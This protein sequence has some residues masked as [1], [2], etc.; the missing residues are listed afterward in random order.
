MPGGARSV[1]SFL[2]AQRRVHLAARLATA[3]NVGRFR[4]FRYAP[5]LLNKN[6]KPKR[7]SMQNFDLD[8]DSCGPMI[9]DALIAMKDQ[10]PTLTF[11]RSCREGICGSCAVN[12]DGTN[13]L[14]CLTPIRTNCTATGGGA[15]VEI[16]ALPNIPVV[17]DL[18]GDLNDFFDHHREVM[19]WLIRKNVKPE[20]SSEYRQDD[21]QRDKLDGLYE[22]VLCAC[23]TTSCPSSWWGP[24]TYLGPAAL[25]QAYRWVVDSRDEFT[26]ERLAKLNDTLKL[27]RCHGIKNCNEVCPK[28]LKPADAIEQL[29]VLIAENYNE[30]WKTL[31]AGESLSA[32]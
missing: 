8:L 24:E 25:L 1:T 21:V 28:H 6:G 19:P 26:H 23:C 29:K 17:K 18:V 22:C 30:E 9:L 13:S 7:P 27:Y 3:R 4:V 11:R 14:A 10:D 31:V 20:G 12:V 5:D 2:F 32:S 16:Q 15:P